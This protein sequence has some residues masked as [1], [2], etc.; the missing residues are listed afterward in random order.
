MKITGSEPLR[1]A[2]VPA[3]HPGRAAGRVRHVP[4]NHDVRWDLTA[5]GIY[6][7]HFGAAPYSFDASGVHFIGFDPTRA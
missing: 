4:G 6:Q 2:V 3:G 7:A 1:F 5:K